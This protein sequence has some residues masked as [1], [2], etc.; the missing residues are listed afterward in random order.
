MSTNALPTG[1]LA[2]EVHIAC[3][4]EH[5]ERLVARLRADAPQE[6][7]TFVLTRPSRGNRRATVLLGE[8]IWPEPGE[9]A[10]TSQSL[11]ISGDYISRALD[12]CIDQGPLVGLALIHTH[13]ETEFGPGVGI[14]S[15]RD[16]WYE[17]R[18]FPTLTL[19]RPDALFA[20]VVVGSTP[21]SV[22]A[23]VWWKSETLAVQPATTVRVVSKTLRLI[24]T[25]HSRWMDHPDPEVVDRSTL[26][27]GV[28]GRRILQNLRVGVV[29]G[30]GTGSI[31]IVTAAMMGTGKMSAWDA[32][33]VQTTNLNRLL[34]ANRDDVGKKKIHVLRDFATRVATASP[35]EFEAIDEIGTSAIAL[36]ALKDCD[37][38][39][40][41]VDRLAPRVPLNDL[42]YVHLIPTF[43]MGSWVHEDEG[44]GTVDAFMTHAMVWSPGMPC[45]RCTQ[46]LSPRALT[47]EAQG[48]QR[49]AER[50][51]GY[52]MKITH[53]VEADPSVLPLN[54]VGAGLAMLEFMQVVMRLT[55]KTPRNLSMRMPEWELDESDLD[56][57]QDC[58]CINDVALGDTI[59]IRPVERHQ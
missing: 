15:A 14:F 18:L 56:A 5:W 31:V 27:W 16:D 36:K 47:R 32:D 24:E 29:G 25:P 3:E 55:P 35:F 23:R 30:G 13:P 53:D 8:A 40:S 42:A 33:A 17:C 22:D 7:C 43:D 59:A 1:R 20:S 9:V 44:A 54:L 51:A 11:E 37:V 57:L 19:G 4:G 39:F 26:M 38:I 48:A 41:C 58:G 10:A 28:E 49:G 2:E 21:S 6:A 46:K 50:G 34:G 12:R 45:G 52:G